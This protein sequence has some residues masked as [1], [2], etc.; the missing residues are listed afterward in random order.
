MLQRAQGSRHRELKT[1][2]GRARRLEA[3]EHRGKGVGGYSWSTTIPERNETAAKGLD[4]LII[5]PRKH[6]RSDLQNLVTSKIQG[7]GPL[8]SGH[9]ERIRTTTP[10]V[11][12]EALERS[13]FPREEWTTLKL[14]IYR[15]RADSATPWCLRKHKSKLLNR[16]KRPL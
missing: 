5:S 9:S 16:T 3:L 4:P 2:W 14:Q 13:R 7:R 8:D 15:S 12:C 1:E 10:S 6:S 11:R